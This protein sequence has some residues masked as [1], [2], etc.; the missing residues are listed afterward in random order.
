MAGPHEPSLGFAGVH[1]GQGL[2][3]ALLATVGALWLLRSGIRGS[4]GVVL[5]LAVPA[6]CNSR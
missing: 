2:R 4:V 6:Y 5:G 3:L 1:G